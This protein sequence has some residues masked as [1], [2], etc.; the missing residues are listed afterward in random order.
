MSKF[1]KIILAA[2]VIVVILVAFSFQFIIKVKTECESQYG[3]CPRELEDG[4]KNLS[5]RAGSGSAR[6]SGN[7][8]QTKQKVSKYLKNNIQVSDYSTQFKFPNFLKVDIL[9]KKPAYM[10]KNNEG[11]SIL[12]DR[13]GLVL[14]SGNS[15]SIIP[16]LTISENLKNI[17]EKINN[18]Q[19]FALKLIE[20]VYEMYQVNIGNIIDNSL[21]VELTSGI[22]VIFPID[23]DTQVLLGSL[24]LVYAKIESNV[25]GTYSQIDLRFK[26][27]VLRWLYVKN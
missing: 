21:T 15:V 11:K 6:E 1:K 22:K 7:L 3:D 26:S 8:Y 25:T 10:I 13:E 9:I 24:R 12:V 27:P 14:S 16:T 4:I 2:S 20:G 17:G 18:N 19:L 23:G 5:R